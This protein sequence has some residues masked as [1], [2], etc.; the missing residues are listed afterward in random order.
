MATSYCA[1]ALPSCTCGKTPN[2]LLLCSFLSHY[3]T[4]SKFLFWLVYVITYNSI[5]YMVALFT[6]GATIKI[7]THYPQKTPN[8]CLHALL[9]SA[10]GEDYHWPTSWLD[11]LFIFPKFYLSRIIVSCIYCLLFTIMI[12]RFI[13]NAIITLSFYWKEERSMTNLCVG[14]SN[15]W[16]PRLESKSSHVSRLF[17]S[18]P[19][20]GPVTPPLADP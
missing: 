16:L 6:C 11:V 9:S 15:K 10:P 19:Q 2:T 18:L 8:A 20:S 3:E 17:F 14:Q 13:Y 5:S 1:A 7:Q 12:L 4:A